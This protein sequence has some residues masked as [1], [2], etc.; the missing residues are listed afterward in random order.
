MQLQNP[1]DFKKSLNESLPG[2]IITLLYDINQ[3]DWVK[4]ISKFIN[5]A[6][7]LE[8]VKLVYIESP[9]YYYKWTLT[10]KD[11]DTLT[12]GGSIQAMQNNFN[13]Y[14][15][16]YSNNKPKSLI[17]KLDYTKNYKIS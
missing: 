4:D 14:I 3:N 12:N 5:D 11:S 10:F 8:L 13:E 6:D 9:F 2:D 7:T 15:K 16:K 1:K 17:D